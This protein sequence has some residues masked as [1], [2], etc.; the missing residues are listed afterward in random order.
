[1]ERLVHFLKKGKN[2]QSVN[3]GIPKNIPNHLEAFGMIPNSRHHTG[4]ISAQHRGCGVDLW[5]ESGRA[6]A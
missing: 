4:H 5:Y 2:P 1:M 3:P 6:A